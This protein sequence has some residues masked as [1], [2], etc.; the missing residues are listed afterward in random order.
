M[1]NEVTASSLMKV[2]MQGAVTDVGSTMYGVDDAAVSLHSA[3]YSASDRAVC[4]IHIA[5]SAVLSVF[6]SAACTTSLEWSYKLG[7][8]AGSVVQL[9]TNLLHYAVKYLY[10]R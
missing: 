9:C 1:Y 5:S 3:A 4:V 7:K 10:D 2:N 6:T 8:H